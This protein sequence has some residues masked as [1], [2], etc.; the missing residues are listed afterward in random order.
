MADELKRLY[1]AEKAN[2]IH[3]RVGTEVQDLR[4]LD[5]PARSFDYFFFINVPQ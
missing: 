4:H 5:L 1:G 3:F 2:S